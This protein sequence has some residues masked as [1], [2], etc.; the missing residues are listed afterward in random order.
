MRLRALIFGVVWANVLYAIGVP[1]FS[2]WFFA[3]VMPATAVFAS[4][5]L[6]F[7]ERKTED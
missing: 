3:S 7:R 2:F 4:I 1:M 5:E 6:I